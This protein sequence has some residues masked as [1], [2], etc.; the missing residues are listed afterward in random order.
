MKN[1]FDSA[2]IEQELRS[3]GLWEHMAALPGRFGLLAIGDQEFFYRQHGFEAANR[4]LMAWSTAEPGDELEFDLRVAD[5]R[6][7]WGLSRERRVG[8][9]AIAYHKDET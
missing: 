6:Y 2:R 5:L 4:N 3:R 1:V 9:D 7:R 8:P